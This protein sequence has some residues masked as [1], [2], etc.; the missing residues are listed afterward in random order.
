MT[1]A[2]R[3]GSP[4]RL[5]LGGHGEDGFSL[6]EVLVAIGLFGVV[7]VG[8]AGALISATGSVA[9]QS[10]RT[11]ATRVVTDHLETLRSLPAALLDGEAGRM[12]VSTPSG[13][14]FMVD[15]AVTRIDAATGTAA[16]EGQVRQVTA[17]VSWTSRGATRNITTTTAMTPP[18]SAATARSIGAVT[19]FPSPATVDSTG[20][21]STDID[22]TVPLQG[23]EASTLVYLS[24]PNSGLPDGAQTLTV[25]PSGLNWRGIVAKERIRAAL[26]ADGRGLVTFTVTARNLVVLH[27]LA[28]QV[29]VSHPPQITAAV[30]DRAP[31]AVSAPSTGKTCADNN[32]CLNKTDVVFTATVAN[33]D[34][35]Q[36][37]VILQYQL[38][39]GSSQ[40]LPLTPSGGV[41]V[42]TVRQRTMKF[43]V[44]TGRPFRFTAIRGSDGATAASTVL[45]NVVMS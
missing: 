6:L 39:D 13:R 24:W 1:H 26:G 32:Q 4:R 42:L 11:A 23:F 41:W 30:I 43:L 40:E 5:G 33:L 8:F 44:G 45:A 19:M 22:V 15:T 14:S 27:T 10:L 36:D 7:A 37:T 28:V 17:T 20:T 21:P 3:N 12:T 38:Y 35:A 9:E 29:A 34:S 16:S 31:I 2:S 25:G 18:D